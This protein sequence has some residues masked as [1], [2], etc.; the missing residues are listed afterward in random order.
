MDTLLPELLTIIVGLIPKTE[1]YPLLLV[2]KHIH[3]FARLLLYKIVDL[4]DPR[5]ARQLIKCLNRQPENIEILS[6]S[7]SHAVSNCFVGDSEE[8][9]VSYRKSCLYS[10]FPA[11]GQIDEK[12]FG[13]N[14][15]RQKMQAADTALVGLVVQVSFS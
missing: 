2:N 3:E 12:V 13:I 9:M 8:W 1:L 14:T 11:L 6:S 4:P 15:C 7:L 5:R 10:F